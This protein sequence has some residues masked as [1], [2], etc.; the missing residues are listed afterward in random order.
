MGF[1]A[2]GL[3]ERMCAS[4]KNAG[5]AQPSAVQ[6]QAIPVVLSGRDII[7]CAPTGTGKTAAFVL[8]ILDRLLQSPRPES[9]RRDRRPRVLVLTPTRELAQQ[10]EDAVAGYGAGCGLRATSVYGGMS[11]HNQLQQLR[12]GIDILI[13]TPGRLLDHL[14]RRS[15]DLSGVETLVLDESD[16]MYDMGFINDVRKIIRSV[17]ASRQTLLFSATMSREIRSLIAEVVRNAVKI[18]VGEINKP[19][20]S[21]EQHFYAVSTKG[22]M[23]LLVHVL[24][25]E[26][27]ETMLVF[28]RTRRGADRI[29]RRLEKSGIESAA[30]HSDR[31]QPQR[32]RA[33]DAF[34][35]R[36]NRILVATDIA[37]RGIDV[38]SISHVVNYDT[39]QFAEDYV[40]RI[41]RTGRAS[42][43][44]AALTFVS[45][46][47]EK[48][49]R[50][51]EYATSRKCRLKLY[52]G[53][54]DPEP[55]S[56]E[57]PTTRPTAVTFGRNLQRGYRTRGRR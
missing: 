9:S 17:P 22:K 7:A 19:V 42:A 14:G 2:T 51:I 34:R 23:D 38:E 44:G 20:D 25:N 28:S 16:R 43:S 40:H 1:K 6:Q 48:Y 39:P 10:I 57:A 30:I 27:V 41:G 52:E 53:F 18:D 49:L 45:S 37:A 36:H 13:A 4:V 11:M 46:E 55:R 56:L 31:S 54:A 50:R 21:V 8:P 29:A 33:L 5:Y 24:R 47:E 12:R 3:S 35:A 26:P 15:V 32:Q